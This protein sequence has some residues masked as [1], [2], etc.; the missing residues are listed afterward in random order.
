MGPTPST[1]ADP[2]LNIVTVHW[3]SPKW[4][5]PQ[6]GYLERNVDVPYRVFASLNGIVDPRRRERFH[7]AEDL[8]GTHAEKLNAL[9][10][11]VVE[12]SDPEDRLLFLDGDAFPVRPVGAWMDEML[13]SHPLAAVR[14]DENLGDRQPHPCFALTTCRFWQELGGDWREGGTWVNSAGETTT[15]V[16]GTLLHQLA[17]GGHRWLPLGRTNTHNPD[18]LWFGVYA[19]RV[20]HHGAGFRPPVSRV[21]GHADLTRLRSGTATAWG[22]SVEGLARRVAGQPSLVTRVRPHDLPMI[23]RA[24]QVSMGKQRRRWGEWRRA[25]RQQRTEAQLQAMF[26]RLETDPEFYTALDD[27][28]LG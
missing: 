25:H 11:L 27:T 22:T 5:D 21:G 8:E 9:A 23:G 7:L 4:I 13:R 26:A 28:P 12:Q 16:G 10:A 19:H 2:V 14:R 20:Y 3:R 17:D 1:A 15:D 6:L 24:V 18:P